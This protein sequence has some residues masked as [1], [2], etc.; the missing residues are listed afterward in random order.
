V[1]TDITMSQNIRTNL[2]VIIFNSCGNSNPIELLKKD[3]IELS[4]TGLNTIC[5]ATNNPKK[6]MAINFELTRL[7]AIGKDLLLLLIFTI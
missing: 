6:S 2:K 7:K 1:K 5:A 4:I 3:S